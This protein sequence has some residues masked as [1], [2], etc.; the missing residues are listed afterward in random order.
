VSRAWRAG[1]AVTL[2]ALAAPSSASAHGLAQRADLPIPTW[3]FAWAAALV[4][5]ASFLALAVLWTKPVF[6]RAGERP[7][8]RVPA[9]AEPIAG[10]IG[11][12]AF[13]AVV[14]AGFAGNQTATA[15]LAPTTIYVIFWVG[16]PVLSILFG[17]V[18]AP[19]NPWRAI[20]RGAGWLATRVAGS[21]LPSAMAYPARAGRWPAALG[22]LAF[23]WVE[24]V[25]VNRSD[26]STLAIL[27]LVY[28]AI[29]L[30][31]M[32]LYGVDEWTSN[33]DAF[34]VVFG[35]YA[36]MAALTWR[37]RR[38]YLR[39]PL[40][41]TPQMP[42]VAGSV[43]LVCVMIGTTAF[44]GFSQTSMW[45]GEGN[46]AERL[47]DVF[48]S[49]GFGS[50]MAIQAGATVGILLAVAAVSAFYWIGV[51][52][53]RSVVP[54]QSAVRL[55][56]LFAHVL[57]PI[58]FAYVVA[59]YFSLLLFQGQAMAFL[60]S[61]PLG[62]GANLFGTADNAIDYNL[63]SANGIWYVQVAALIIGHVAALVLAHDRALSLWQNTRTATRSQHW[64][65]AVMVGFTCLGLFIL[66][67]ASQ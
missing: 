44:D 30:I 4:L 63:I 54:E 7:L 15:N 12:A 16:I 31:G 45:V 38:L 2:A 21:S 55:A 24:L 36:S 11:I 41:G 62:T 25:Y 56:R 40:S 37:A 5:V 61:D 59:H 58:S 28:A 66:S 67:A 42:M 60:I 46:L 20:G 35:L 49:L 23:A 10:A 47:Q 26:P 43:A 34:A 48:D 50:E 52:G 39:L 17:D 33:G 65:L 29:M 3:L 13:V 64:M 32:S 51:A 6:E 18:F 53:M 1:A 57:V 14:Y 9:V 19:V 27:A 8:L 22:I